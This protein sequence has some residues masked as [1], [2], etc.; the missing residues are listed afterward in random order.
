[1]KENTFL[2]WRQG[3][4]DDFEFRCSYRITSNWGNSGI[5]FR[6]RD[7]GHWVV[8]GYQADIETG[9]KY[10]GGLYDENV[11]SLA[12]RGQKTTVEKDGHITQ[13]PPVGDPAELEKLIRVKDWN[14]Y[15]VL[16]Q[17]YHAVLKINGHVMCDVTD[18]RRRERMF[19]AASSRC[20]FTSASRC[21][22]NS[23]TFGS[24]G[25]SWAIARKW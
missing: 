22:S 14:D 9:D 7:M 15:D 5:Q 10:T 2:I 1:M 11:R 3:T 16:V 17:G 25:S 19:A 13:G 23:K 20:S 6:S 4:L 21:T 12:L 18:E 24:S 8:N